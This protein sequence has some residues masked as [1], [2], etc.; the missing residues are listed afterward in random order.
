MF[1]ITVFFDDNI[2]FIHHTMIAK[3]KEEKS[4]S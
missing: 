3:S 2:F 1:K 4:Q